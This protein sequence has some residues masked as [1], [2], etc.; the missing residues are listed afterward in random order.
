MPS[1]VAEQRPISQTVKWLVRAPDHPD[2]E[3][4]ECYRIIVEPM[5]PLCVH[6]L[7]LP[8]NEFLIADQMLPSL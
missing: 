1:R 7:N 6:D 2:Y 8:L 4:C 5:L 3:N